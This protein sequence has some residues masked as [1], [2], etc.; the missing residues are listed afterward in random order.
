LVGFVLV[1]L[2][3]EGGFNPLKLRP[4]EAVQ[5]TLFLTTC[6]GLVIAWRWPFVGGAISTGG[7]LLFFAVEFA[8]TGGFPKGLVFPP[9]AVAGDSLAAERLHQQAHVRRVTFVVR[10]GSQAEKKS[11]RNW[12]RRANTS[13]GPTRPATE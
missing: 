5:M 11:G 2:I 6:V 12:T 4:V 9:D 13:R 7:V 8:V 1:I 10:L 3:G